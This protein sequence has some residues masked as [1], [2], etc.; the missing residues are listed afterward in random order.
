MPI[1]FRK[2]AQ[3]IVGFIVLSILW[4]ACFC[5]RHMPRLI[6]FVLVIASVGYLAI[7]PD[8]YT[9]VVQLLVA[10]FLSLAGY[11]IGSKENT[12]IAAKHANDR[13]VPQ[14][15]SVICRLMTLRTNVARLAVESQKQCD[16]AV[17]ELPELGKETL[18][19]LSV[20]LKADCRASTQRLADITR[21]LDDVIG[22]WK[23]F[24][25]ANCQGA[26]CGRIEEAVAS[27]E[28]ELANDL[29]FEAI[30]RAKALQATARTAIGSTQ[31][32]VATESQAPN[33]FP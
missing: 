16:D 13:W 1:A 27:R 14:A 10:I 5:E 11:W 3:D 18:R 22:D 7:R 26:E 2:T 28:R 33:P 9:P 24:V 8:D 12:L 20:K 30:C 17:C 19:P 32:S 15:E 21:Q 25:I 6:A 4:I 31:T 23:R 29:D